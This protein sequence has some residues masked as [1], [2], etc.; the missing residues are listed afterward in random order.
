MKKINLKVAVMAVM[1]GIVMSACGS[2]KQQVASAGSRSGG[3]PFGQ[4][5]EAPCTVYD[6]DEY[7]AATGIA[8]GPA[9]QKGN[10]QRTA[11]SN[12]QSLIRQKMQH[13]YEGVVK[14]FFE[15]IGANKGTDVENQVIGG[16]TQ[17]I[18]G[19]VN[20]TSHSCLMWSNVDDRGN[21][22][23]YIGIKISKSKVANA[24]ADNLSKSEKQEIRQHAEDFRKQAAEELKKY[25]EE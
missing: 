24:I 2:V 11:L 1:A 19:I 23:C 9:T 12:G 18:M 25:K 15:N 3:E 5:R 4:A 20:N 8:S 14:D 13:A 17:I 21:I 10:L 7:F 22:E 16:G 6:D